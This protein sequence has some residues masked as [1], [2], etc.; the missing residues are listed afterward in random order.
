MA[1]SIYQARLYKRRKEAGLCVN[2]G[3]ELDRNGVYCTECQAKLNSNRNELR[4]WYQEGG[5]CPRCGKELL[6]GQEKNCLECSAKGYEQY[7]KRDKEHFNEVHR[8]WAKEKYERDKANGICTRCG[9][10]KADGGYFTCGICRAK[11]R[12]N[13]M[14]QSEYVKKIGICRFCNEP[15]K[16]GYK[17][18]EKHHQ[19]NVDKARSSNAK[20]ARNELIRSGVLY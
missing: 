2:C 9:K 18:C 12:A 16:D 20:R 10:R 13:R 4:K 14:N 19:M 3:K 7:L 5:I 6:Y 15:V 8:K 1:Q 17:V 11:N